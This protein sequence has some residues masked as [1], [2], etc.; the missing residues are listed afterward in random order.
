MPDFA[1]FVGTILAERMINAA[2]PAMSPTGLR[3][4][5]SLCL[6]PNLS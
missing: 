4:V 1:V 5:T 2:E 6:L 3:D